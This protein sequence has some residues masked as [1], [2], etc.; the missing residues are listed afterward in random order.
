MQY[1]AEFNFGD[2]SLPKSCQTLSKKEKRMKKNQCYI[3]ILKKKMV[4]LKILQLC[5]IR[6]VIVKSPCKRDGF[7]PW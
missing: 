7:T 4:F 3:S 5:L 1:K 6:E 2:T